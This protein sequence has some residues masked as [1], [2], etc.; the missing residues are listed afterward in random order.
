M[1]TCWEC[2]KEVETVI[3]VTEGDLVV[4][5]LCEDCFKEVGPIRHWQLFP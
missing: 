3:V 5:R 4:D 2:D 1:Q